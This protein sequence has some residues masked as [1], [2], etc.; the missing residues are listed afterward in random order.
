MAYQ[1]AILLTIVRVGR[2]P[3]DPILDGVSN[4][5]VRR[6][7]VRPRLA[8]DRLADL[9]ADPIAVLK[10]EYLGPNGLATAADAK[11]TTDRLFPRLGA[12]LDV[13][14]MNSLYSIKPAYGIDFGQAGNEFSSGMLTFYLPLGQEIE[15]GGLGATLA[16]SPADR[17]DLGMVVAPFG[18]LVL[19][20]TLG[21]WALDLEI[22]GDIPAFAIGPGGLTLPAAKTT[23]SVR[24]QP[25]RPQS[26]PKRVRMSP[27]WW[28]AQPA[29]A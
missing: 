7:H 10:A 20:E 18:E 19:S 27:F 3:E 26:C 4:M 12:L 22:V 16:L 1:L 29:P 5:V 9:L 2:E 15:G 24:G 14:G 6:P 28:E 8:L 11:A 13:L 21:R 17:G 25:S 23:P